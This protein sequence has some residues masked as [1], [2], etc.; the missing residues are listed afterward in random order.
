[1]LGI[2]EP[3]KEEIEGVFETIQMG[4]ELDDRQIWIWRNYTNEIIRYFTY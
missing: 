2:D 1:M 3:T 4:L